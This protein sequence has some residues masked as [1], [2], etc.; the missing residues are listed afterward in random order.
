MP[1]EIDPAGPK[2]SAKLGAC[3]CGQKYAGVAVSAFHGGALVQY[4]CAKCGRNWQEASH[5][6]P[7]DIHKAIEAIK[8]TKSTKRTKPKETQA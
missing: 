8:A 3:N 6:S 1:Q 2:P 4:S 5:D 7:D